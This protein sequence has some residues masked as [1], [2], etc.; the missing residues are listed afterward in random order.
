MPDHRTIREH[1]NLKFFGQLLHDPNLWH[2]NRRS[3]SGAF[4]VGLFVAFVPIPFQ[5][6][7]AAALAI[8]FR[9]NLPI[10]ASLVWVTNPFT[11]P[12][13]FYLAYKTGAWILLEPTR[14]I[15]FELSVHWLMTKL[16]AI[17]EPF[18]LGCFLFG[19]ICA[20]TGNL[21]MRGMW[22]LHVIKSWQARKLRRSQKDSRS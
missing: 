7:L 2:L 21:L 6:V 15:S 10:A 5:M 12:P 16:E 4:S 18:L 13:L 14:N 17:W 11:I 19:T 8:V 3:V 20:I 9:I 22:R 1:K